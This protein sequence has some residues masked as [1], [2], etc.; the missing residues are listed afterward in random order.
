M[1]RSVARLSGIWRQKGLWP[2]RHTVRLGLL[3][4]VVL[5]TVV[6]SAAPG[7]VGAGEEP[8]AP[9]PERH[10][11]VPHRHANKLRVPHPA[12][13]LAPPLQAPTATPTLQQL[14]QALNAAWNA[15]NWEEALR[16][17]NQIIAIDPNYDDI[18]ERHYFALVNYGYQLLAE[19]RCTEAKAAFQDALDLRPNGEEAIM[20]LELVA[21]Y[22]ATPIPPTP[23]PTSTTFV[24]PLPTGTLTP[25]ATPGPVPTQCITQTIQY[26]VQPGDTL[27]GLAQRYCTTVQAIM[28]AN[29]MMST[30]LRAYQTILVPPGT[31]PGAGPIVHIVQPQ[32]TLFSIAQQY[33]TTVWATMAANGL[34]S[35]SIW[36][37]RALF[38]PS[39]AQP[40]PIIH[41]VM[42]GETLY[43][44]AQ[45]YG[46]TVATIMLANNLATYDL[47]VYQRLIIPPPGWTGWPP[48]W[49]GIGPGWQG[50][51]LHPGRIYTVQA[52]DTLYSIARRFGTT[53]PALMTTNH[54]SSS[55]IYVGMTLRIP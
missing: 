55:R 32:E 27:F 45:K 12:V 47:Y 30:F 13:G 54:L 6:W 22:C 14:E 11:P 48:S 49:P 36:A 28:A 42:P 38:I 26:T 9:M 20:G 16:I 46:L 18:Q 35:T 21:R 15:Q 19:N 17:I 10:E 7:I 33:N 2:K 41:I 43:T 3:L 52:G 40:G 23:S 25:G 51:P 8:A 50:G 5:M 4:A 31:M 44:I 37:Y 29:G 34:T 39:P 53:V 24:T 1:K